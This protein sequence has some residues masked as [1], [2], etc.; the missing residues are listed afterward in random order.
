M[1]GVL[2]CVAVCCSVLQ[3]VAVASRCV[4][5]LVTLEFTLRF[6]G[7]KSCQKRKI[8][9]ALNKLQTC[10]MSMHESCRVIQCV[11]V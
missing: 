3:C 8:N 2:L 6:R 11:A 4:G 10:V 1:S 5:I 9:A 7:K